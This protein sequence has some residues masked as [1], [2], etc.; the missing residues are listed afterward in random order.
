MKNFYRC[1]F[2]LMM[3]G[4]AGCINVDDFGGYWEKGVLDPKLEGTWSF[5]KGENDPEAPIMFIKEDDY[6]LMKSADEEQAEDEHI[7]TLNVGE[8]TFFLILMEEN[9]GG[10]MRYKIDGDSLTTYTLKE[11]VLKKA[12]ENNEVDGTIEHDSLM[13]DVPHLS[14]LDEATLKFLAGLADKPDHWKVEGVYQR[15]MNTSRDAGDT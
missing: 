15:V 12:I 9:S 4:L 3:V 2:G 5:V 1:L 11:D 6:Y 13:G 8:H 7:K 14:V 10:I